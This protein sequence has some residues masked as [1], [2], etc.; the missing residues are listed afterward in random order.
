MP[1]ILP[2]L[3]S[4]PLC[5]LAL[6]RDHPNVGLCCTQEIEIMFNK[7]SLELANFQSPHLLGLL[8]SSLQPKTLCLAAA[9]V[10]LSSIAAL[11]KATTPSKRHQ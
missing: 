4:R 11:T 1:F 2:D 10:A 6:F 9:A 7:L 8:H 3:F 5:L